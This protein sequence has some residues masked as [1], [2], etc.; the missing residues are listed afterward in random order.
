M[1]THKEVDLDYVKS[2]YDG[3]KDPE[4]ILKWLLKNDPEL[5][6]VESRTD[7]SIRIDLVKNGKFLAPIS[8]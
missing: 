8:K 7:D 4:I 1:M 6:L 2:N 5:Q 3:F